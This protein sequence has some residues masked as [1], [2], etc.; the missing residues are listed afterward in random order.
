[1]T[2]SQHS[3]IAAQRTPLRKGIALVVAI[4]LAA[5]AIPILPTSEA[6]ATPT[7]ATAPAND[8]STTGELIVVYEDDALDLTEAATSPTRSITS[9]ESIGAIGQTEIAGAESA[10]AA[11]TVVELADGVDE[12]AAI[13][14]ISNLEEVRSVHQNFEYSLMS[15]TSDPYNIP[16]VAAAQNQYYLYDSKAIDAWDHARTDSVVTI[17]VLDTG[18]DL[19]HEDLSARIDVENAYDATAHTPLSSLQNGDANGHGTQVAG[20]IAAQADNATGIAGVSYN[21]DILPIKVFDENGRCT[22]ADLL[23]AYDYLEGLM[24]S[25]R[26]TDLK[27]INLSI[28]YY[29]EELNE[30]DEALRAAI[31]D[32]RSEHDVLTICAGGNG[33]ASGKP[34]TAECYPADFGEAISVTALD[35]SGANAAF[36]DYNAAKDISAPGV[37]ILTTDTGND[38]AKVT[39]SSMAAP[40]VTGAA[41]LLWAAVPSLSADQVESALTTT[42]APVE[43]NAHPESGSAGALD[44]LAA[45]ST[46]TGEAYD[47]TGTPESVDPGRN[48]AE[49]AP[50]ANENAVMGSSREDEPAQAAPTAD[51]ANS[52]RFTNGE[53]VSPNTEDTEP[54]SPKIEPLAGTYSWY[55]EGNTWYTTTNVGTSKF[56]VSNAAAF[57]IDVSEHQGYITWSQVKRSGVQF[58]I[59]RCGYGS[60]YASQDDKYWITNVQNCINSGMPFGVYIYSYAQN[61]AEASSEADHVLRCLEKAA[62]SP[63][64]VAYPI[65]YDLEERSMGTTGNRALLAQMAQTFCDKIS[66]AG[67]MP[68]VYANQYWWDTYLTDPSFNSWEKWVAQ[69]PYNGSTSTTYK[70]IYGMWQCMSKGN[71]PGIS[72]NVDIN[73]AYDIVNANGN[74]MYRMYNP[75]SGEHFYTAMKDERN[76][77]VRAGWRYE[78]VAWVAPYSSKTPVYRLYNPNAGDHHYTTSAGERDVLITKGWRSEGIGWYSDDAKGK[79]LYRLYNP[80]ARAGAHHYTLSAGERDVLIRAGWRYE[81]T[82]WHGMN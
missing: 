4:A 64:K 18:C 8:A 63:S 68:G 35:E 28:G 24:E 22:T 56:A 73:F 79:V 50:D 21:A 26:V 76:M 43:G 1:M 19:S 70:G 46:V 17:A 13:A 12:Q 25:G 16:D 52:W 38:Y 37:N 81:G 7:H 10:K 72:T 41:A 54:A 78:G 57:G 9:L 32:M 42:A 49:Q 23:A 2:E 74:H 36:A 55:K 40:I 69:Y 51:N 30:A 29:A 71:I 62:L 67:Y 66:K 11:V 33:D 27:A 14:E 61:V 65:Y 15:T 48:E 45:L 60:N 82:C 20:V 39:G 6:A 53:A 47:V 44:A 59:I 34:R 75:N 3:E 31:A 77:L 58:A 5:S 80:N